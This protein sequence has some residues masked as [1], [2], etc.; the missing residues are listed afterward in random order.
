MGFGID[1]I[2]KSIGKKVPFSSGRT[3]AGSSRVKNEVGGALQSATT[4]ARQT[5]ELDRRAMISGAVSGGAGRRSSDRRGRSSSRSKMPKSGAIQVYKKQFASMRN[6]VRNPARRVNDSRTIKG[7]A[8][9]RLK[10]TNWL[11]YNPHR[12]GK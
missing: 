8:P 10:Q 2:V 4:A 12:Y 1:K 9:N 6:T 5:T 11:R 3:R 7:K